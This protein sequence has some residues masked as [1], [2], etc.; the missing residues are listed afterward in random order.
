MDVRVFYSISDYVVADLILI[1]VL[2]KNYFDDFYALQKQKVA[3]KRQLSSNNH[4]FI[5]YIYATLHLFPEHLS[6]TVAIMAE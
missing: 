5:C 3:I 2:P 6:F 1:L 4:H